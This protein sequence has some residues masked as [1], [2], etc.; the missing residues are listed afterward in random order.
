VRHHL[1][2]TARAASF[3]DEK[4]LFEAALTDFTQANGVEKVSQTSLLL[5]KITDRVKFLQSLEVVQREHSLTS[6]YLNANPQECFNPKEVQNAWHSGTPALSNVTFEKLFAIE[7]VQIERNKGNTILHLWWRSLSDDAGNGWKLF[8]HELD[9]KGNILSNHEIDLRGETQCSA[10]SPLHTSVVT[11]P[12]SSS[13]LVYGIGMGFF[14]STPTG[15]ALLR[16]DKGVRDLDNRRV[17]I[18]YSS[19]SQDN[20]LGAVQSNK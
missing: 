13:P 18:A 20:T 19:Q 15:L 9:S 14:R 8:I 7:A 4:L 6:A 5:L 12:T 16:A 2:T 17:L 11:F 1:L 10:E 3:T